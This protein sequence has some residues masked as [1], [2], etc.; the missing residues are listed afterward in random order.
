MSDK[1]FSLKLRLKQMEKQLAHTTFLQIDRW[2]YPYE[3][4]LNRTKGIYK[5]RTLAS[6]IAGLQLKVTNSITN[7]FEMRKEQILDKIAGKIRANDPLRRFNPSYPFFN[8]AYAKK[9]L[10]KST[11]GPKTKN[12]IISALESPMLINLNLDD[13]YEVV[14]RSTTLSAVEHTFLDKREDTAYLQRKLRHAKHAIIIVYA[15]KTP[16]LKLQEIFE[17]LHRALPSSCMTGFALGLRKSITCPKVLLII[18]Q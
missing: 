8:K 16:L 3:A 5:L 6:E 15:N 13:F 17:D 12:E 1:T 18:G 2:I 9:L 14:E 4:I 7:Y 10:N 11:L